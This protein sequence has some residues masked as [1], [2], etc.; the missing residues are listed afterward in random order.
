MLL[1]ECSFDGQEL[2]DEGN[3]Q[4]V[5]IHPFPWWSVVP[6]GLGATDL[7]EY[8]ICVNYFRSGCKDGE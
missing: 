2:W 3:I 7:W 8:G 4:V 1:C 5:L 6:L